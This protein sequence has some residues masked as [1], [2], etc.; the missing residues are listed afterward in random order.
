MSFK[1]ADLCDAHADVLICEPLF[2]SFG[3]KPRFSG[4]VVTIKCHE[5]NS[6]V[7]EA[8]NSPG[9]GRVL[10]VD[11]GGSKRCAL[12][13]DMLGAAAVKNGWAGIIVNGCVRD[14]ADLQKMDLGVFALAT[15]PL[16]SEKRGAG[17][18][19]VL[20]T[21]GGVRIAPGTFIY[22]DEDGVIVSARD[23]LQRS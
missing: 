8:V 13:G 4:Q 2:R 15:H 5:D 17:Q 10:V 14:S 3:G 23:L 20:V 12:L 1:T 7:K 18:R 9:E 19:D 6:L 22:A 16:K 11:G 21:I